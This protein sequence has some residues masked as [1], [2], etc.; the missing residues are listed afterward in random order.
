MRIAES[1]SAKRHA[2]AEPDVKS[3]PRRRTESTGG[4][5]GVATLAVLHEI[6][7]QGRAA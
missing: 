3:W 2:Q 5:G 1:R 7:R 4:G 6:T